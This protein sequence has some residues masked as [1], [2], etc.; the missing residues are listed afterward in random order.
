[1]SPP[2]TGIC[3][4]ICTYLRASSLLRLLDSLRAQS[5]HP[6]QLIIV[7]ASP[8]DAT[9]RAVR[10]YAPLAEVATCVEYA[11][12]TG[13]LA[14]LT[15]QRNHAL[16][17]VTT[18]LVAFFDDDIICEPTCLEAME[19]VHRGSVGDVV[20]VGAYIVNQSAHPWLL[21]RVRRRLGIVPALR[22]GRYY[23]SGLSIPWTF[24][25]PTD[26]TVDG[27]WLPGGATMWRT[28]AARDTWFNETF[29]GYGSSED[30]EFSLRITARGRLLLAGTARVQHLH[31]GAGR[32][33]AHEL[34]YTH[35]RNAYRVHRTCLPDR[36]RRD[37]LWFVYAHGMDTIVQAANLLRPRVRGRTARYLGGR[38]RFFRELMGAALRSA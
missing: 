12:V 21:W 2:R 38:L 5:R 27:D 33:D 10:E 22:P 6:D 8:D 19:A 15:R 28:A 4:A 14:G 13:P 18:D 37:A 24:L 9:E 26:A 1:M 34:G 20:G 3:V 29:D 32:P 16:R 25:P 17:L 35:L 30:L 11:R 7:D 23:R 36:R 31:D